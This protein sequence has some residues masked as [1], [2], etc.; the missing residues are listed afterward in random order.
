MGKAVGYVYSLY[1]PLS[2]YVMD[3]RKKMAHHFIM[4]DDIWRVKVLL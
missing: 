4:L 1:Y 2:R 3:G